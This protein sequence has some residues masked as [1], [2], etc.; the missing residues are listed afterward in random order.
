[1]SP[2]QTP[3]ALVRNKSPPE[4]EK[5]GPPLRSITA[6]MSL[7]REEPLHSFLHANFWSTSWRHSGVTS[8]L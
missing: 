7:E 8:S 4:S 2:R 1:M 3:E 5:S 6:P